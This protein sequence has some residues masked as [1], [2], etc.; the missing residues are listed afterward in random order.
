MATVLMMLIPAAAVA[1]GLSQNSKKKQE[2]KSPAKAVAAPVKKPASVPA[3]APADRQYYKTTPQYFVNAKSMVDY[4]K[5]DIAAPAAERFLRNNRRRND[6]PPARPMLAASESLYGRAVVNS[7]L[8]D[9]EPKTMKVVGRFKNYNGKVFKQYENK[10][11]EPTGVYYRNSVNDGRKLQALVG[12]N[13]LIKRVERTPQNFNGTNDNV[14]TDILPIENR[15]R[16]L[17]T[18]KMDIQ[19]NMNG[20][21]PANSNQVTRAPFGMAM[22]GGHFM[23]R[24]KPRLPA[25]MRYEVSKEEEANPRSKT[26]TRII[27]GN[28]LRGK[29]RATANK[30]AKGRKGNKETVIR[31]PKLFGEATTCRDGTARMKINPLM[32][33]NVQ[34]ATQYTSFDDLKLSDKRT[35]RGGNTVLQ[36]TDE[37][38]AKRRDI[39]SSTCVNRTK[40]RKRNPTAMVAGHGAEGREAVFTNDST[41]RG[42]EKYRK[43]VEEA[44]N[45][46]VILRAKNPCVMI[47]RTTKAPTTAANGEVMMQGAGGMSTA[48]HTVKRQNYGI[49]VRAPH[50]GPQEG[51]TETTAVGAPEH[52]KNL[53]TDNRVPGGAFE[54]GVHMQSNPLTNL[55]CST[56]ISMPVKNNRIQTNM[57]LPVASTSDSVVYE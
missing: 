56:N 7:S 26:A 14:R 18:L 52:M 12:E 16:A 39:Q 48:E 34:S 9:H 33:V 50:L 27:G 37:Y 10:E 4:R 49:E 11:P 45:N 25:S 1:F 3:S 54:A 8:Y 5:R 17:N 32:Q 51:T 44:L 22:E 21:R 13:D 36:R 47:D 43:E 41:K 20:L 35:M 53:T 6:G 28:A 15:D 57:R 31:G 19:N 2:S 46:G 38:G 23:L 55:A 42:V 24:P 29:T 30:T 40:K